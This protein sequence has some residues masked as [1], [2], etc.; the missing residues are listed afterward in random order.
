MAASSRS[1][2]ASLGCGLDF[3][4]T[5]T[6]ERVL[7]DITIE[8]SSEDAGSP[9]LHGLKMT[10]Q[11]IENRHTTLRIADVTTEAVAFASIVG[12]AETA[13]EWFEQGRCLVWTQ[14]TQLRTPVDLLQLQSPGLAAR[15][16]SISRRLEAIASRPVSSQQLANATIAQRISIEDKART[17]IELAQEDGSII[18]LNI[19]HGAFKDKGTS[20]TLA[21]IRGLDEPLIIPLEF[22]HVKAGSQNRLQ[23]L[24]ASDNLRLRDSRAGRLARLEAKSQVLCDILRELWTGVVW[25]VLQGIGY[26]SPPQNRNRIRWCA[27]GPLTFLPLHAA[28]IYGSGSEYSRACVPDF[29]VSSYTPTVTNLL[30][31]LENESRLKRQ[32][33]EVLLLSQPNALPHSP[34]PG[35]V[36]ETRTV[37]KR[38]Q[39][40]N[41]EG[42]LLEDREVKVVSFYP[43]TPLYYLLSLSLFIAFEELSYPAPSLFEQPTILPIVQGDSLRGGSQ[44]ALAVHVSHLVWI[45]G[46]SEE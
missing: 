16:S 13:L 22:G 9:A 36:K 29:V 8:C 1:R 41:I 10:V 43:S 33:T 2:V 7:F 19:Q 45:L 34:I 40:N 37:L 14:V 21:L 35:T 26:S 31:K 27:S 25:P 11:T 38:L 30:E 23:S 6:P 20:Q 18:V 28:G 3:F 5:L 46:S 12:C 4:E 44:I 24:L 42:V 17:H 32:K 15:F 39:E